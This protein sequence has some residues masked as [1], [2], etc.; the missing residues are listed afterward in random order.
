LAADAETH[1]LSVGVDG[2]TICRS[3]LPGGLRVLTESMPG[4]RAASFGVWV[5]VGSMDETPDLAGASHYLEH[6]L[7]KGTGRRSALEISAALDGIG[8]DLNA[9]TTKEHT[10][11]YAHVLADDLPLAVDVVCDVVTDA[12]LAAADVE[13][14][15]SV[16]LEE[17]AM[18]DDDPTDALYELFADALFGDTP[19][20]R[21]VIGTVG[22]IEAMRRDQ[23]A[24]YYEQQYLPPRMV[25]AAAGRLDHD[26]V[27]GL[28]RK[29]FADRLSG[30][31]V[32]ALPRVGPN[33][34]DDKPAY[35]VRVLHRPI[36]QANLML[37]MY[38]LSRNDDR[39]FALSVL[40]TA[41]GGGASSRLFQEIREKRGLV[42]SIYSF[43]SHHAA[44]GTFGVYAGCQPGKAD[45]VLAIVRDQLEAVV[46]KGFT[47]EEIARGKGQIRGGMVLGMEDAES[48]MSRLGKSELCYGETVDLDELLAKVEAVTP[49]AVREIAEDILQRPPCLAVVGPF[50]ESDFDVK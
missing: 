11:Y 13:G 2:G 4:S 33:P 8:G 38:G 3:T 24:K 37:G 22:S 27:V 26:A 9:F 5:G 14:E 28:V 36:E 12:Q 46:D 34:D 15:R 50:G 19:L 16:I 44:T 31:P 29:A 43:I 25:V 41:L 21:P 17:I 30:P 10:C 40:S 7:F 49:D 47:D 45:E 42:Y 35:P 23:V 32:P 48:R 39:R 6:L 20:G 1:T 18:R